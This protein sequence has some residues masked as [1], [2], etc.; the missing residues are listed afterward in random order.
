MQLFTNSAD[1]LEIW[2]LQR[3]STVRSVKILSHPDRGIC[4]YDKLQHRLCGKFFFI[5]STKHEL[6]H[7]ICISLSGNYL[8]QYDIST[9]IAK[10]IGGRY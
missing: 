5:K 8:Y 4:G 3:D 10:Y 6:Y 7:I 1:F 2:F 9:I